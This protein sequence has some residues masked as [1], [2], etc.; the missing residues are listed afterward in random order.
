[1]RP[2]AIGSGK[3][4]FTGFLLCATAVALRAQTVTI[5]V[6]FNGA[7]LDGVASQAP[8]VL[9]TDGNLYGTT[10]AGGS[11]VMAQPSRS[12]RVVH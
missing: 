10:R 12:P 5:L 2:T 6:N 7:N 11:A 9:G 3:G 8:L 1:M 4:I